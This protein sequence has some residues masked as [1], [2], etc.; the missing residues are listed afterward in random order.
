MSRHEFSNI[1]RAEYNGLFNYLTD[2]GINIS[3]VEQGAGVEMDLS[4]DDGAMIESDDDRPRGPRAPGDEESSEDESFDPEVSGG[5]RV[6][7]G[8]QGSLTGSQWA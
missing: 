1:P 6:V 3:N 8:V 2:K 4:D 7:L 5:W